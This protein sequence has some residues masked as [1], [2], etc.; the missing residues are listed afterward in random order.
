MMMTCTSKVA[1]DQSDMIHL[2]T[3]AQR[4]RPSCTRPVIVFVDDEE[5]L[6]EALRRGLAS[7]AVEWDLRFF[8]SSLE[9]LCYAQHEHVD[10]LVTDMAMPGL[11]G[12][13]L[14]TRLQ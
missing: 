11:T 1:P 2:A 10:V 6:L 9:A 8:R 13:E 3:A 4:A 5:R 14:I 12:L 7:H